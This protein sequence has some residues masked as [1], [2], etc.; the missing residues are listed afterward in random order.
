VLKVILE[1]RKTQK[2]EIKFNLLRIEL[3]PAACNLKI[4]ASTEIPL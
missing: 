3:T 1:L 2:V 4:L